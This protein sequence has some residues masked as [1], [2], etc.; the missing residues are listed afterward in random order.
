MKIKTNPCACMFCGSTD[1]DSLDQVI[2]GDLLYIRTYC[3]ECNEEYDTV[4]RFVGK[5]S[6][7]CIDEE[8]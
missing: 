1:T 6:I 4:F 8:S 2:S 7:D 3:N 5:Y